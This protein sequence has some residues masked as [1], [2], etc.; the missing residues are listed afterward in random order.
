VRT[1]KSNQLISITRQPR[2]SRPQLIDALRRL[3]LGQSVVEF[4]SRFAT[5][6]LQIRPLRVGHRLVAGLP[7]IGI[8]LNRWLGGMVGGF[9]FHEANRSQKPSHPVRPSIAL[10]RSENAAVIFKRRRRDK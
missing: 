8:A 7:L 6:R 5:E 3:S 9:A 10:L 2:R 1:K 4:L